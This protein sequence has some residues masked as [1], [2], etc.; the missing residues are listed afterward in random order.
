M[1]A[2]FLPAG[3]I[4]APFIFCV[5]LSFFDFYPFFRLISPGLWG[6]ACF[7]CCFKS[8]CAPIFSRP[9]GL[10][11]RSLFVF[12]QVFFD[13]YP[14]FRSFSQGLWGFARFLF[15]F[16]FADGRQFLNIFRREWSRGGS[17]ES[18]M[19]GVA[20]GIGVFPNISRLSVIKGSSINSEQKIST[21][22]SAW[23]SYAHRICIPSSFLGCCPAR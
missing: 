21:P 10:S 12:L 1:Y 3:G 15:F 2:I 8:V 9:A 7:F 20:S 22:P 13:F 4:I 11:R 5:S 23:G 16:L 14:F 18:A 6:F 17:D 19:R